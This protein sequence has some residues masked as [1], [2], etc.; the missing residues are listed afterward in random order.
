MRFFIIATIILGLALLISCSSQEEKTNSQTFGAEITISESVTLANVYENPDN[1]HGKELLLEG[2]ITEVCQ[3]KGCWFKMTD[4]KNEL[5]VKFKDY[6]FF[7]P[8]DAA[9]S[10][11]KIQGIFTAEVDEHI[12]QEASEQKEH[13]HAHEKDHEH[14]HSEYT[15]TASAVEIA[16]ATKS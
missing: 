4:G 10:Q 2:K 12:Q 13:D 15:F 16:S 7:V 6:A 1:F 9:E 8:K 3:K 5:T 11:V 14:N